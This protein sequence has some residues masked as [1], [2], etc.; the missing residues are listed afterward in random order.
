[1]NQIPLLLLLSATTAVVAA[2][3]P[4]R[5]WSLDSTNPPSLT[6]RGHAGKMAGVTGASLALDGR[7]ILEVPDSATLTHGERGFTMLAWFNL[8]APGPDQQMLVA[9]NRYSLNER[10]WGVMID[11]DGRLRLHVHQGGWR[12][13]AWEEKPAPGRWHLVSVQSDLAAMSLWVN[14]RR[15]GEIALTQP[16]PRTAAPLT[17]GGVNDNGRIWQTLYGALDE[18]QLFDHA[19]TPGELAAAYRPVEA[20][21]PLSQRPVIAPVSS[22]APDPRWRLVAERN[23]REDRTTLVFDGKSPDR[24]ACDTTLRRMPDGSWV[25]IMLGGGDTE[26]MPRNRVF[27]TRSLDEGKSW[28]PM[29]PI[30]LGVKARNPNAALVPSELMVRGNRCTLFVATHDGTFGDWKEWLTHSDDSGRTWSPLEPAPGRLH[31]RTFIRNHIVTRDGR[32]LLPF[33]HYLRV[34][35]T[36][37]INQGRRFSAPTNPRN[38][39]L[40]SAD[41]GRT[42]IEHGDIRL[43]P[44]DHYHGW[45]ENNIVEL[46]D[47]RIAMIIRADR[48]G[49]VLHYAESADGGRTWP[50]FARKTGIPSPGSKATLYPLGGDAVALLHNPNPRGRHPLALWVSFDGLKTWPYQRVLVAESS[51]GPG[52]ALNYPDGFVSADRRWLHFAF[53]DARYRAV[54]VGARLPEL[55]AADKP[56]R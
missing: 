53:D 28:S 26:P 45:A 22:P 23:A 27:L 36:R 4:D 42:W 30:D 39:V 24:L 1:M 10:E 34:A 20:R 19:L 47:G 38:G 52:K 16:V 33:Q 11:K 9:K 15:I 48:L 35:D 3:A 21:H 40:M 31:D 41:G 50:E 37:S 49:G 6:L 46:G 18:I 44:D 5:H 25:M 12:T 55:P 43:S 54:Y 8:H 32:I 2:P 29:R 14:G 7:S 13:V 17:F 56:A 51:K